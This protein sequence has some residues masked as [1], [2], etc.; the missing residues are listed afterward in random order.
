MQHGLTD[1]AEAIGTVYNA[2]VAGNWLSVPANS[3]LAKTAETDETAGDAPVQ[4]I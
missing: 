1:A 3:V 2:L 4:E